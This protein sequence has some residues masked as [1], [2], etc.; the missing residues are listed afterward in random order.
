MEFT[1]VLVSSIDYG[2]LS[3]GEPSAIQMTISLSFV[4]MTTS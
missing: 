1:E 4:D 2:S 3:A